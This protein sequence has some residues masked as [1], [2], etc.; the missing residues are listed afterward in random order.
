M[1]FKL[2]YFQCLCLC[3][4]Y[5]CMNKMFQLTPSKFLKCLGV[6]FVLPYLSRSSHW[7][8]MTLNLYY[9]TST[10]LTLS[11]KSRSLPSANPLGKPPSQILL[12]SIRMWRSVHPSSYFVMT[13]CN[14]LFWCFRLQYHKVIDWFLVFPPTTFHQPTGTSLNYYFI[15]LRAQLWSWQQL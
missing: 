3:I 12:H 14:L 8:D 15:Q 10:S 1:C 2:N 5:N 7:L 6:K 13:L 11:P 9:C 4:F